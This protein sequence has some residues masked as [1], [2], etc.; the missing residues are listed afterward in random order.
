MVLHAF[1]N[2]PPAKANR[3]REILTSHPD[4]ADQKT[5]LE[6]ISIIKEAGSIEYAQQKAKEIVR[7]AW[8][9]VDS[10]IPE[11]LAKEN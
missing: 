8:K 10:R 4:M 1:K 5:I 2:S 3:L 6:A 9:E 11:S 7:D